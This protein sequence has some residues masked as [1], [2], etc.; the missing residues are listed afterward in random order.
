MYKF[1]V[2]FLYGAGSFALAQE[3]SDVKPKPVAF[4]GYIETTG[5]RVQKVSFREPPK[6]DGSAGDL[7]VLDV[8]P[9]GVFVSTSPLPKKFIVKT[10]PPCLPVQTL[11]AAERQVV[12]DGVGVSAAGIT[13]NARGGRDFSLKVSAAFARPFVGAIA[14]K[15]EIGGVDLSGCPDNKPGSAINDN[16]KKEAPK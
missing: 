8:Q 13:Q 15:I 5:A 4:A 3:S 12:T 11:I 7:I 2:F 9:D 14:G 1:V 10:F 16:A 6:A